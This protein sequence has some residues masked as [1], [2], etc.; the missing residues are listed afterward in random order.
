MHCGKPS[1]FDGATKRRKHF[2]GM[3]YGQ[4]KINPA[5]VPMSS[6]RLAVFLLM[7]NFSQENSAQMNLSV[8]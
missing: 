7:S 3:S 2:T 4:G 8:I 1:L 6:Y 5:K